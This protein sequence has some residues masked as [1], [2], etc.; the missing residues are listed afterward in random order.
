MSDQIFGEANT[1]TVNTA[2]LIEAVLYDVNNA[3]CRI[4]DV[5]SQ[6]IIS[7]EPYNYVNSSLNPPI[8]TNGQIE[9]ADGTIFS[10]VLGITEIDTCANMHN[11]LANVPMDVVI[12]QYCLLDRHTSKLVLPDQHNSPSNVFGQSLKAV[13]MYSVC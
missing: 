7:A 12:D 5:A 13:N 1:S 3:M 10:S 8:L 2:K 4:F 9:K 11:L 6:N